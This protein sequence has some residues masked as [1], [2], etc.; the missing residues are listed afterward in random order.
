MNC[1]SCKKPIS[2]IAKFC[3]GCGGKVCPDCH[4]TVNR[5]KRYCNKCGYEFPQAQLQK[6][7]SIPGKCRNCGEDLKGKHTCS[8][9]GYI[10]PV[11]EEKVKPPSQPPPPPK[12]GKCVH[13]SKQNGAGI[14]FC[15]SCHKQL[16][17][18]IPPVRPPIKQGECAVCHTQNDP[19]VKICKKC[20]KQIPNPLP[21]K[22]QVGVYSSK[23]LERGRVTIPKQIREALALEEGKYITFSLVGNQVIVSKSR[24]QKG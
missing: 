11:E 24:T 18:P 21:L 15:L 14:R 9:C 2:E 12:P 4:N 7:H 8:N 23:L 22:K 3:S 10:N 17:N 13:C 20:R 16:P 19:G 6:S 5:D 1:T